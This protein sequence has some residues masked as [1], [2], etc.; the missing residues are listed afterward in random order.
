MLEGNCSD[1]SVRRAPFEV[2]YG[3]SYAGSACSLSLEGCPGPAGQ[4][5]IVQ[6]Q[7]DI[8]WWNMIRYKTAFIRN[9][10]QFLAGAANAYIMNFWSICIHCKF[11]HSC[12]QY[13]KPASFV[14][15]DL[16]IYVN[17]FPQH[18]IALSIAIADEYNIYIY[19]IMR[20][21]FIP[22][23][24]YCSFFCFFVLSRL[25]FPLTKHFS[26]I[27]SKTWEH[28]AVARRPVY[29]AQS[30][31]PI[32]LAGTATFIILLLIDGWVWA[33][34]HDG[35]GRISDLYSLVVF[36]SCFE[37]DYNQANRTVL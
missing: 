3:R 33:C 21:P 25:P 35:M 11:G 30:A 29:A 19:N 32:L 24:I 18:C 36:P 5:C 20:I 8:C 31:T 28:G 12:L 9:S 17:C 27:E 15:D 2:C 10:V 7:E 14:V 26:D 22:I 34:K 4:R 6:R 37:E 13:Q 16:A 1:I 23:I